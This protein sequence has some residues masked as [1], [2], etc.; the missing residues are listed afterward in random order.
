MTFDFWKVELAE[1]TK[2]PKTWV[3][4]EPPAISLT[5]PQTLTMFHPA[6]GAYNGKTFAAAVDSIVFKVCPVIP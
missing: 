2:Y 4:V 3:A 1:V 6:A 5:A